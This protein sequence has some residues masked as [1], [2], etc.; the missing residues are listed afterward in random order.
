[1]KKL[2]WKLT[3]KAKKTVISVSA[4]AAAAAIAAGLFF[5]WILHST[6]SG[7]SSR[8]GETDTSSTA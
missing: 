6:P 5:E 4:G 8:R 3:G 1:M 7:R 2:N